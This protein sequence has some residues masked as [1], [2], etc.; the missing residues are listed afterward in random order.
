MHSS[1]HPNLSSV[2]MPGHEGR[3]RG[4]EAGAEGE[5]KREKG[6]EGGRDS[7]HASAHQVR[8]AAWGGG[9][10]HGTAVTH[11]TAIHVSG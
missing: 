2:S 1:S 3:C 7:D 8:G 5:G 4:V 10:M 9:C 6:H 11:K